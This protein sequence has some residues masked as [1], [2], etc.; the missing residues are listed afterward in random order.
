LKND[1]LSDKKC[2]LCGHYFTIEE[3][4]I[5]EDQLTPEK[6]STTTTCKFCFI[7]IP[8][9]KPYLIPGGC[10]ELTKK[11]EAEYQRK[12][13]KKIG[14]HM[15]DDKKLFLE[16][17]AYSIFFVPYSQV[18][19]GLSVEDRDVSMHQEQFQ[20]DMEKARIERKK[21]SFLY[22]TAQIPKPKKKSPFKTE[23]AKP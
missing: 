5:E 6:Y 15:N 8:D 14:Q 20:K 19:S 1:D 3:T 7:A 17:E 2:P 22:D 21:I 11:W 9:I 4:E 13:V 18:N 23:G 16:C 10:E 12:L